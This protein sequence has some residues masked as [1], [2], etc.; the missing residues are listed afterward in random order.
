MGFQDPVFA[1]GDTGIEAKA[2]GVLLI[3]HGGGMAVAAEQ[4]DAGFDGERVAMGEVFFQEAEVL[5]IGA[6]TGLKERAG[7]GAFF[8]VTAP[9]FIRAAGGKK[10]AGAGGFDA[11]AVFGGEVIE[12]AGG[13]NEAGV[14]VL[15]ARGVV[16]AEQQ[17]QEVE[18]GEAAG[19]EAGRRETAADRRAGRMPAARRRSAPGRRPGR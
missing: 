11:E 1:V 14:G 9:E 16:D 13:G 18:D 2:V 7:A 10:D 17:E 6:R 8:A 3:A 15:E 19:A 12:A 4:V 5:R